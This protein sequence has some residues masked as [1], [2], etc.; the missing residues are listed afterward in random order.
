MGAGGT[1]DTQHAADALEGPQAEGGPE[2]Q[3]VH[4]REG[5]AHA[6]EAPQREARSA[7]RKVHEAQRGAWSRATHCI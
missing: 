6:R 7:V 3:E 2:V 5:G 1:E 4:D